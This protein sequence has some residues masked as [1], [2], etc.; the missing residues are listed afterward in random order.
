ML[1]ANLRTFQSLPSEEKIDRFVWFNQKDTIIQCTDLSLICR[2][3]KTS[4][5]RCQYL[6]V[7][8]DYKAKPPLC[9]VHYHFRTF[10]MYGFLK[11]GSLTFCRTIFN[12]KIGSNTYLVLFRGCQLILR[13]T[14]RV[15][16]KS[17][18]GSSNVSLKECDQIG[19]CIGLWATFQSLWQ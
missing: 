17:N 12:Y 8:N 10:A 2:Q 7:K 18:Y 14:G 19:W 11:R 1:I 4:A 3:Q 6:Q 15:N 9:L 16:N 13:F 5:R